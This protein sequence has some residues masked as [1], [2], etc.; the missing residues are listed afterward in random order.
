MQFKHLQ[1]KKPWWQRRKKERKKKRIKE[2]MLSGT[3]M[4]WVEFPA[5]NF[6]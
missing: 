6:M 5:N 1:S 3:P 4:S 2:K